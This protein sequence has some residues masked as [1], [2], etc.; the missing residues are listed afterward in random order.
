MEIGHSVVPA[1]QGL[2]RATE[3]AQA[4]VAPAF[5]HPEVAAVIAHT[6]VENVAAT[7]ALLRAGFHREGPGAEPGTTAYRRE[8][9]VR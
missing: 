3:V 4:L 2:G 7:R 5:A 9:G 8:G 6:F 1:A